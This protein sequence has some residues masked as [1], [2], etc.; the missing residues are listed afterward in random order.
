MSGGLALRPVTTGIESNDP[1]A[2]RLAL[3]Q[4]LL[5]QQQEGAPVPAVEPV[6]PSLDLYG[7]LQPQEE[8]VPLRAR[9]RG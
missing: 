5:R 7:Y 2:D 9:A 6:Q 4:M 3:L 8:P 1:D